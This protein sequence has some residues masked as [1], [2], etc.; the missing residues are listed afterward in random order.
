MERR[1]F[2]KGAVAA[3]ASTACPASLA[4]MS[5]DMFEK[6][7]A[8]V[9]T[10]AKTY[11]GMLLERAIPIKASKTIAP[12]EIA[13][14][15]DEVTSCRRMDAIGFFGISVKADPNIRLTLEFD[16]EPVLRNVSAAD[17][18]MARFPSPLTDPDRTSLFW[19]ETLGRAQVGLFL[20]NATRVQMIA[21]LPK[22][23]S[24]PAIIHTTLRTAVYR[25]TG[26][27]RT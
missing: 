15:V 3:V 17:A 12:G 26:E 22:W 8:L 1:T 14:A 16:G 23:M 27:V 9:N 6:R 2:L 21:E 19:A 5:G 10:L 18:S 4:S 7:L 20:T 11:Y 24:R 13:Y 25:S